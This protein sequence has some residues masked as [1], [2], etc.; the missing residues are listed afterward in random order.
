MVRKNKKLIGNRNMIV[1]AKNKIKISKN[2]TIT[3][4]YEIKNIV[5]I[6]RNKMAKSHSKTCDHNTI[7][8]FVTIYGKDF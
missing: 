8:H 7:F 1:S 6:Y 5:T 4:N 2:V 3:K